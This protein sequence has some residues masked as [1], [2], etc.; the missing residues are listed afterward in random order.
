V[1]IG[2]EIIAGMKMERG[3]TDVMKVKFRAEKGGS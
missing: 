1:K 3:K 2:K